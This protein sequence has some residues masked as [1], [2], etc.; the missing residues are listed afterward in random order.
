MKLKKFLD[1]LVEEDTTK[2]PLSRRIVE[3]LI[4]LVIALAVFPFLNAGL[5]HIDKDYDKRWVKWD[6]R[7]DR[8]FNQNSQKHNK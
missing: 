8:V 6:L 4:V 3:A 5:R 1:Q 7:I 2:K